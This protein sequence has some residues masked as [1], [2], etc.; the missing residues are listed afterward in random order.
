MADESA[1]GVSGCSTDSSVRLIKTIE[2]DFGVQLFDRLLLAFLTKKGIQLLPLNQLAYSVE[3]GFIQ[4]DT[5]Y[6]NNLVQ[7]KQELDGQLDDSCIRQLAQNACPLP[8]NRPF[9]RNPG[10]HIV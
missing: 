9:I 6:F 7:T 1:S 4:P 8:G 5:P 2:Q 10:R 3:H